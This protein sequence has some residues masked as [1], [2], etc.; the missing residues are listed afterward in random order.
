MDSLRE[1]IGLRAYGQK[2]PLIEYRNEA[3]DMFHGM[4]EAIQEDVAT[5]IMRVT[6]KITTQV[7]E[8]PQKV[9]ENRYEEE[10]KEKAKIPRKVGEQI[11][12]NELCPCGS[13]KKYKKC[14]GAKD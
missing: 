10:N 1:G 8:Q 4:I 14:C 6:P 13:G 3:F 5:Y 12:R 9:S 7:P 11:G 2:D